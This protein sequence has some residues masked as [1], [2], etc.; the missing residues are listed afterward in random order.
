MSDFSNIR[1]K[2]SH[3]YIKWGM[4]DKSDKIFGPKIVWGIGFDPNIVELCPI[5]IKN[6]PKGH[7][8]RLSYAQDLIIPIIV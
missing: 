4:F 1:P 3:I 2:G 7:E 6:Y 8:M 5:F